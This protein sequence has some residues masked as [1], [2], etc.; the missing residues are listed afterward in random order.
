MPF[1][2]VVSE[3]ARLSEKLNVFVDCVSILRRHVVLPIRL[4]IID[5][6]TYEKI[7]SGLLM[8]TKD[9]IDT[10]QQMGIERYFLPRHSSYDC[11]FDLVELDIDT[12]RMN[13]HEK[14]VYRGIEKIGVALDLSL[15]LG[16]VE[17][18]IGF[19]SWVRNAEPLPYIDTLV[20]IMS[21]ALFLRR[22]PWFT[23]VAEKAFGRV[24]DEQTARLMTNAIATATKA[25]APLATVLDNAD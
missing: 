13:M 15:T 21:T 11:V 22:N 5:A 7:R 10:A 6:E 19:H 25:V 3:I 4:P 9:F 16:Y 8:L 12:L 18:P 1:A 24:Y 2:K 23:D 17:V 14:T 20:N